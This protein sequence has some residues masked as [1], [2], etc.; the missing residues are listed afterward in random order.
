MA[1]ERD[2]EGRQSRCP[3]SRTNSAEP[4]DGG[5]SKSTGFRYFWKAAR[6]FPGMSTKRLLRLALV[7]TMAGFAEAA[8]LLFV[9]KVAL[10]VAD[11]QDTTEI[12]LPSVGTVRVAVPGL[13]VG[14]LV[15]IVVVQLLQ[16]A[17]AYLSTRMGADT[18]SALRKETF[19]RFV[20][21]SWPL[22]CSQREG[23]LQELMMSHILRITMAV[24]FLASGIVAVFNVL[25][26]VVSAML[27]NALAAAAILMSVAILFFALRPVTIAARR[28]SRR[29]A[30]STMDLAATISEHVGIS[31]ETRTFDVRDAVRESGRRHRRCLGAFLPQQAPGHDAA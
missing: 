10:A 23:H 31:Q 1:D 24:L 26:L 18:M 15:L 7:S 3:L 25:A 12:G 21:S 20:N 28:H 19:A 11:G 8:A 2:A 14:C 5:A 9:V 6:S 16:T 30:K 29:Q 17:S 13:F 22:Q 27:V 4:G